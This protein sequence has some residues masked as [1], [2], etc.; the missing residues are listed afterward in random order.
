MES[1]KLRQW[2]GRVALVAI[3]W[4]AL[5]IQAAVRAADFLD[6]E[7]AFRFSATVAEDGRTVAA[8]FSI[9]DGYYLYHERF[10]FIA[11][12]GV[13]LGTPQYPPGKVKFDETFNKEVLTYRGDVVVRLPVE[14]G[15]GAFTLTTRLQGCADRGLCYPPEQRT[16][17]LLL[18][19]ASNAAA[20]PGAGTAS[21]GSEFVTATEQGR[22]DSA[23]KSRSLLAVLPIFFVLGLLLSFTPC[24]L[25]MLPIL[26]SIIVGESGHQRNG[27][28]QLLTRTRGFVLALAYALGMAIVYTALGVAAG[29]AGEGL[30]AALQQPW[31][32]ALFA[33]LLVALA[34]SMFGFYELQLPSAWQTRLA[35]ASGRSSGG[36]LAGVFTMGAI[37]ALI[38]GPCVAAPLAGALLYISQTRDV[39]IG[40]SAL[41]AMA[42]GMSVPLL[43]V[44]VS[45]GSLLPRAGRWMESI[46]RLFGVLLIAVALWI[47]SP[48]IPAW[49][50]MLAW[51]AFFIVSATYLCALDSL[52]MDAS[53]WQ[54]LGK[55]VGLVLLVL[56]AVQIVGAASGGRDVL[57]PLERLASGPGASETGS[58]AWRRVESVDQ[59]DAALAGAN[60]KPVL[61]DFY[62]DW[63]VSCREMDRFTF[64]DPRVANKLAGIQLLRADVTANNAEDKALLKRFGLFGP[65]GTI[66]FDSQGRE[67]PGTRVIGFESANQFLTSLA[68]AVRPAT[69]PAV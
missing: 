23:L 32:L 60:G 65:P 59:L 1:I 40:G 2:A 55:G 46:K 51:A 69:G 64:S 6:P 37:S 42:A 9:A 49:A 13:Q 21:A 5:P 25:P 36:T 14:S 18:T 52:P 66:F 68:R 62:A 10:A 41:F 56:G 38:V 47:V 28:D 8:R 24:V 39:V 45:A 48:V 12:D 31:V 29:L 63:C 27:G 4:L 30:A 67:V 35:Q 57:R 33:A 7:D 3:A 53:G 17:Q 22:I 61:L 19:G 43:L 15:S 34:L 26:S 58:V 44:G 20:P 11:S 54:R 16:A 50:Q